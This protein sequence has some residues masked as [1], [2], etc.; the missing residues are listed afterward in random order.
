M[1]AELTR[2][3]TAQQRAAIEE[4]ITAATRADGIAPLSEHGML[5]VRHGVDD[6]PAADGGGTVDAVATMDG[7]IAGYAYLDLPGPAI[8]GAGG[9]GQQDGEAAGEAAGELV[10]H[11]VFRRRGLGSELTSA[12]TKASAASP[13]R[14][15]AHGDLPAAAALATSAGFERFRALHQLRRPLTG[16]I[17]AFALPDGIVLRTFRPGADEGEWLRL[18]T[19]AFAGHPEQSAWTKRDLEL[20]E[21]EPWF[22]PAGLFIAERDGAMVGFHWTKVHPGSLGEVYVLGI[23]PDAQGGG[24]GRALTLAG[25][26][27]LQQQG[28]NDVMLYVDDDNTAAVTMY[29]SLGFGSW[30][31]D[32]MYRRPR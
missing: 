28:L 23:D 29:R 25:L 19:R 14:I 27:H 17:P 20:R 31:T 13:V 24:L 9:N 22:D 5:H 32:V 30:R 15:W 12:L 16:A 7:T 26:R 4:L 18:N 8:G 6:G 3:L 1:T 11:P 10:V 2:T 21:A